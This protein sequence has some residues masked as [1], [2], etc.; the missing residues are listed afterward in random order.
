MGKIFTGNGWIIKV[1][2]AEHPPLQVHLLH[3]IGKAVLF[4]DGTTIN[5]GVPA[6]IVAEAQLWIAENMPLVVLEWS[7]MGNPEKR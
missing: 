1:Q 7:T 5:S 3:P 2:G 6:K 4:L